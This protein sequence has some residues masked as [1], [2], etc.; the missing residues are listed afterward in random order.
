M[1][2]IRETQNEKKAHQELETTGLQ[3]CVMFPK[4]IV[5]TA[6]TNGLYNLLNAFVKRRQG[7]VSQSNHSVYL[8]AACT[9]SWSV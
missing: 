7:G 1:Y 3:I 9:R 5:E 6:A 4:S 8:S 2:L